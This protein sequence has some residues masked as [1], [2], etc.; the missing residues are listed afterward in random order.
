MV[1]GCT[2]SRS[3][4]SPMVSRPRARSRSRWLGRPWARRRSSTIVPVNGFAVAGAAAGG[5]E[6]DGDLGVGVIVEQPVR[7]RERV[8]VGLSRAC[9]AWSGIGIVRLVVCPPRKRTCRWIWSVLFSVTSSISSRAMRLRSRCGVAGSDQSLGKSAAS[10]RIWVLRSSLSAAL[11]GGGLAVV[12]VLGGLELRG[13]CRSSRPRGC[14][15]RAGCRGR[16]RDSGGGRA[17]RGGGLA[18]RG[19]RRSWS[20]SPAR[21]SSSAWTVS[22]TSSASGVTVWSSSWLIAVSTP[23]P[24]TPGSWRVASWMFSPT[25]W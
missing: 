14:R 18:R 24:G 12:V 17:R 15:R 23:W 5:V 11:R 13:A 10:W 25:H 2:P 22:A 6:L 7:A 8:G 21:A 3:A 20:A 16:L 1:V 19:W 4:V 9:H